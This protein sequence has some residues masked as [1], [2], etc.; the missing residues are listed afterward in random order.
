MP[1]PPHTPTARALQAPVRPLA[2][3]GVVVTIW[4]RSPELLLGARHYTRAV[5]M[6]AA[7]T[8]MA[9]LITLRP[10]FQVRERS[11]AGAAAGR[12]LGART[13]AP[14]APPPPGRARPRP[15]RPCLRL[16]LPPCGGGERRGACLA[17]GQDMAAF[18]GA[19]CAAGCGAQAGG[20]TPPV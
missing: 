16:P 13:R 15:A 1:P 5:D 20:R 9:E 17:P 12:L 3:N 18:C 11:V 14:A 2:D 4:Y 8:I 19:V 10:L 7:G 6:W